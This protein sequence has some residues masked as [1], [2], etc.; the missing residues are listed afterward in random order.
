VVELAAQVRQ[1]L[2]LGLE[3]DGR[4]T[5]EVHLEEEAPPAS[6]GQLEGM[7]APAAC[8]P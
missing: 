6:I 3:H 2:G 8:S 1:A 7:A 4:K 5:V